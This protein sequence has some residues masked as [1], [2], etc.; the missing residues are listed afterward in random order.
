MK[1]EKHTRNYDD[2]AATNNDVA[3]VTSLAAK[4]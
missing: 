2:H 3:L 4:F 1:Y